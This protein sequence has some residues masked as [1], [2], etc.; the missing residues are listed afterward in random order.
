MFKLSGADDF[1]SKV[2]KETMKHAE[3]FRKPHD[4]ILQRRPT[5]IV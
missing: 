2:M 1:M 3:V 4:L 5:I